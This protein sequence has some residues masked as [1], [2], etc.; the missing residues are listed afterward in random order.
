MNDIVVPPAQPHL[1]ICSIDASTTASGICLAR[2]CFYPEDSQS[3]TDLLLNLST[4]QAAIEKAVTILHQDEIPVDKELEKALKRCRKTQRETTPTIPL[5][6]NLQEEK[7][8]FSKM[9]HQ[10]EKIYQVIE[11]FSE[12]RIDFIFLEDYAFGAHGSIVQL[13]EMK[14]ILKRVLFQAGWLETMR[15]L[16]LPVTSIKKI[17]ATSGNADKPAICEMMRRFGFEGY[18][19]LNNQLDAIAMVLT[20]FYGIYH[21]MFGLTFPTPSNSKERAKLKSWRDSLQVLGSRL[22]RPDELKQILQKDLS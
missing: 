4:D 6:E 14:G 10:V 3:L 1:T 8:F 20:G 19:K 11:R 13:A 17:A 15:F 22:G 16:T 21:Q 18:E 7:L 9:N 12:D 2:C 5:S